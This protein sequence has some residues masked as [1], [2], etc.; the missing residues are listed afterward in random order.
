MDLMITLTLSMPVLAVSAWCNL[1]MST[2]LCVG[3]AVQDFVFGVNDMPTRA[4]KY[5]ASAFSSIG[6]GPAASAAV[7]II[8][9]AGQAK[10]I[11]RLGDDNVGNLIVGELEDYGVD[12][13]LVK[14]FEKCTSS[15]SA[16]LVDSEGE[17]LII[18]YLDPA[19]PTDT[20]WLPTPL[21]D[22][23]DAVLADT[24][25]P[26][27]AE[28]MLRQAKESGLPAVIDAD[29]PV[30]QDGILLKSATHIAFSAEGLGDYAGHQLFE[31][32][33]SEIYADTGV[34]CCVTL[35][36]DGVLY[37]KDG[38]AKRLSA[39]PVH[40]VDTLGAGDV[41]HG[42]FALALAEQQ[43]EEDAICFASAAAALKVQNPGGRSGVPVRGEVDRFLSY[44]R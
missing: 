4:E 40:P 33:L 28:I 27:A 20:A 38:L 32:A 39:F 11:A 19:L 12:C 15:L 29:K 3:Q 43:S 31:Q 30:P 37:I 13:S 14:R 9:L 21:P 22:N 41:W 7:T 25:W 23:I 10:L 35:G 16:V 18:N 5:R 17:R 34:W 26:N 24:R 6:G 36:G 42:A 8:R 44:K 1:I 2:V